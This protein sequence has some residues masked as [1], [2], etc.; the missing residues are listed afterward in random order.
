MSEAKPAK[1]KTCVKC[2][3]QAHGPQ[4]LTPLGGFEKIG[5][6]KRSRICTCTWAQADVGAKQNKK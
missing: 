2:G 5:T 1:A 3:H 4:C 6:G